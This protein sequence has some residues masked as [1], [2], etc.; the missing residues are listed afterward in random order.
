MRRILISLI[1][2]LA[3][4]FSA[5]AQTA[6]Q[7]PPNPTTGTQATGPGGQ[8]YQY[9][10]VKWIAVFGGTA[11]LAPLQNPPNGQNNYAPINNAALTGTLTLN[12]SPIASGGPFSG[13]GTCAAN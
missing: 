2:L 5:F 6:F 8:L 10:G 1:M 12:G 3:L 13:V 9:N 7:W 11:N 4:A